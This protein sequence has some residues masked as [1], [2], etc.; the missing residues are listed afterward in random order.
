MNGFL[1]PVM[2][3]FPGSHEWLFVEGE[4]RDMNGKLGFTL[5]PGFHEWP[6]E[7][8][9]LKLEWDLLEL[10]SIAPPCP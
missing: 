4:A 5:K 3:G 6:L 2:N 9:K 7:S 8:L 1:E 10:Q